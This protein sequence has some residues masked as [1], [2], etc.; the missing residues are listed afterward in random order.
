MFEC[1]RNL[2]KIK[3]AWKLV[4]YVVTSNCWTTYILSDNQAG[5]NTF[6]SNHTIT[7]CQNRN[8][9]S[10][11]GYRVIMETFF[12]LRLNG[13]SYKSQQNKLILQFKISC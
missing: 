3:I 9:L 4:Y 13:M 6:E 2:F 5:L 1:S 12:N 10:F 7:S 8:N 11:H